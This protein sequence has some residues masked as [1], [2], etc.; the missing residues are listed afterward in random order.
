MCQKAFSG[1]ASND[2]SQLYYQCLQ[3]T[4]MRVVMIYALF[5]LKNARK[6]CLKPRLSSV[7]N[8]KLSDPYPAKYLDSFGS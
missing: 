5:S 1:P 8:L 3:L 6:I 2:I 4:T 7:V